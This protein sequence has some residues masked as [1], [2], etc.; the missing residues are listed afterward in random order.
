M[1]TYYKE[2]AETFLPY[3]L[4]F[5]DLD[6][7]SPTAGYG[8]RCF[9]SWKL[10]DFNNGIMQGGAYPL[11]IFRDLGCLPDEGKGLDVIKRIFYAVGR[12]QH[13]NGSVDEAFPYEYAYSVTSSLAFDLLCALELIE[14]AL[15]GEERNRF[16]KIITRLIEFIATQKETHG[17]ISNH[18]ATAA[19]AIEKYNKKTGQAITASRRILDDILTRQSPDGW[20]LEYEGPDP[21]YQTL[22]TYYLA[23]VYKITRDEALL[24]SL[25]KSI[26]FL[27]YFIHPDGSMGGEYGS[28]NTELFYPAGPELLSSE[29]PVAKAISDRMYQAVCSGK[30]VT[31]KSIDPGN[32]IPLLGNYLVAY[33]ESREHDDENYSSLPLP[34]E[35]EEVDTFFPG[36]NILIR[37][38]KKYYAI[39]SGAKGGVTKIFSKQKEK[40]IWDDGGYIGQLKNGQT[41]STQSYKANPNCFYES[42]TLLIKANFYKVLRQVPSLSKFTLLRILNLTL[43]RNVRLGNMAKNWIVKLLI[44]GKKKYDVRLSRKVTFSPGSI[45]V[46]DH[47]SKSPQVKFRW[48]E[49]GRKFCTIHMASAKYFQNQFWA[50]K[51]QPHDIDLTRFNSRNE[52]EVKTQISFDEER[53]SDTKA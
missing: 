20:Y 42:G 12:T 8:D 15:N 3:L 1:K 44:T 26:V 21:G 5:Y 30:T 38:N 52:I 34:C 18:L 29:I 27:S 16:L 7:Y 23:E 41:I 32:F 17:F 36:A 35:R 10:K 14:D 40:I 2:L 4:S 6:P 28:R 50:K 47:L 45:T 11:A 24:R 37:G 31:L 19:A 33:H 51:L 46:E 39:I 22:C 43:M 48:L 49:Y 53:I 25:E 13:R 9:W